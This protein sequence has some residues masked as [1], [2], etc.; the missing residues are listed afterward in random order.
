[1]TTFDD[2]DKSFENKFA[3]DEE[4]QFKANARRNKLAGLWAADKLGLA[5]EEAEA[6]AMAVAIGNVDAAGGGIAERLFRDLSDAGLGVT[7]QAVEAELN[8]LGPIA[9]EQIR[10]S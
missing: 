7:Q 4:L 6:Y 9:R 2:R 3:H 5:G 8:R 1:M 10:N